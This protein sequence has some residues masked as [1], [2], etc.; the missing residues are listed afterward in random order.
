MGKIYK[1]EKGAHMGIDLMVT[2]S[3]PIEISY[4]TFLLFF[5]DYLV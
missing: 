1:E 4:Q 2:S 5:K 3:L